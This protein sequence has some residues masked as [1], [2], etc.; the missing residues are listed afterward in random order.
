MKY[1]REGRNTGN[2]P[3][4]LKYIYNRVTLLARSFRKYLQ[5]PFL[6]VMGNRGLPLK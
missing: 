4:R 2:N 5:K 3:K 1:V 6:L